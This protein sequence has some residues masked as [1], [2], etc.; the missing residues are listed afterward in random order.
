MR[1]ES[2][3]LLNLVGFVLLIG[4]TYFFILRFNV[5]GVGYAWFITYA[6]IAL[7]TVGYA[8]WQHWI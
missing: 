4:L 7:I 1:V 2:I 6:V 5:V 8:K 3:A